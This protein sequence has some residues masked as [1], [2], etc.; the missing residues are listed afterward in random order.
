VVKLGPGAEKSNIKLGDRVGIKV[1]VSISQLK[2]V[3]AK[4]R[5]VGC[6]AM[7]FV[8]RLL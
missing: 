1:S 3:F 6:K 5:L 8:Y 7:W 4:S 2:D